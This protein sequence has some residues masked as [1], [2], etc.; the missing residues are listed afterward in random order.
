M[1]QLVDAGYGKLFKTLVGQEYHSWMDNADRWD[2]SSGKMLIARERR[3]LITHWVKRSWEKIHRQPDYRRR[4]WRYFEKTGCLITTDG[5]NDDKINLEGLDHYSVPRPFVYLD[6]PANEVPCDVPA[7]AALEP[8]L[9]PFSE[10]AEENILADDSLDDRLEARDFTH[11]DVNHHIRALYTNGWNTGTVRYYNKD[12]LELKVDVLNGSVD[13]I[14]LDDFD[15]IE[16]YFVQ[17]LNSVFERSPCMI[18][19]FSSHKYCP[20][21]VYTCDGEF[22][23]HQLNAQILT[24]IA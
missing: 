15:G 9:Q 16:V 21:L 4:L 1:W 17:V 22:S 19:E 5:S 23:S 10:I 8:D 3:F 6:P 13:Y 2:G 24:E 11:K 14:S 20:W 7:A 12:L 18:G